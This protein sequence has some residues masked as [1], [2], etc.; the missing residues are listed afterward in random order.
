MNLQPLEKNKLALSQFI[1]QHAAHFISIRQQ[2]HAC[3]ELGF[4][5][6]QTAAIVAREL[7]QM[8]LVVT[9]QVGRTGVVAI[10]DSGRPGK[11]VALRA[12]LDA[13][14]IT[15]K[16]QLAYQS[17]QPD[18]MHACGHDGHTATLLT[19]A[20][21]LCAHR[22][23]FC[24]KVK[25][26]FQPAEENCQGGAQA[27]I[28]EGVLQNPHV[29][30]I[31]AFHNHPG[32]SEGTILTRFDSVLSSNTQ[33]NVTILGK[34]GHVATP[35]HNIDPILIAAM[36]VQTC[37]ILNQQISLPDNPVTIRITE[38]N[39]GVSR[40][41]TPDT[42][43]LRGTIR[44][45]SFQQRS[46]AKQ[47]LTTMIKQIAQAQGGDA[48]IEMIDRVPPTVNTRAETELVFNL[49]KCVLGESRV[50]QKL[51]PARA[52]EDFSFYLEKIPGCYFFV[53]NGEDT[54]SCHSSNYD[55]N[56]AILPLAA[57]FLCHIAINYL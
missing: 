46:V 43:T 10:I 30:A 33:V 57:E 37:P 15:E 17:Q 16:N 48:E 32:F 22:D 5:E 29:D 49:A 51:L 50:Q 12:E 28:Q 18:K 27:M 52:S 8:G 2:I 26:I 21:A 55:F 38:F 13:L 40:N 3:P 54:A 41:V 14:P 56:D 24:G 1:N 36:I 45:S 47:R 44:A 23:L 34:G 20:K 42:A 35:E 53:G 4:A 11:T 6:V 19:A 31:F 7:E 39:A 25:L 9:T